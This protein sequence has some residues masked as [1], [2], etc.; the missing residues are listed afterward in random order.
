MDVLPAMISQAMQRQGLSFQAA[1]D[2]CHTQTGNLGAIIYG[3]SKRPNPETLEKISQ[4]LGIPYESLALAAY[5]V[6]LEASAGP[7]ALRC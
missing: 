1:A 3:R 7:G 4:G 5:G 6:S 2:L